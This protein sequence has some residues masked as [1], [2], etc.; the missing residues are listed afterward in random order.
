MGNYL[1]INDAGKRD[2]NRSP[3]TADLSLTHILAPVEKGD[4]VG[5]YREFERYR[6]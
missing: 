4:V 2:F 3:V 5:D 6:S 1:F